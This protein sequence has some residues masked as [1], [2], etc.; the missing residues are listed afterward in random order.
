MDSIP[1]RLVSDQI[2]GVGVAEMC[3]PLRCQRG[4]GKHGMW[5]KGG[6]FWKGSEQKTTTV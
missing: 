6:D 2:P 4:I 1:L 3:L 5:K